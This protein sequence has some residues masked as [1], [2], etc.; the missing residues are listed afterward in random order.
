MKLVNFSIFGDLIGDF[1]YVT[2][3]YLHQNKSIHGQ[4]MNCA[5][6]LFHGNI[7]LVNITNSKF[8]NSFG[9]YFDEFKHWYEQTKS[10]KINQIQSKNHC[11]IQLLSLSINEFHSKFLWFFDRATGFC[12]GGFLFVGIKYFWLNITKYYLNY[13]SIPFSLI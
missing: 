2:K 12:E 4:L 3:Q 13:L 6:P 7:P 11:I 10:T 9:I 5:Q 8:Q 1:R